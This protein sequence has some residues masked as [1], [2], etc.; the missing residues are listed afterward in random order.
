[1]TNPARWLWRIWQEIDDDV[2]EKDRQTL[3]WRPLVVL[4]VT[5]VSLTVQYYFGDLRFF[6]GFQAIPFEVRAGDWGELLSFAWWIGFRIVGFLFVGILAVL[7]MP[8]ERL[9]DYNLSWKGFINHW[10]PYVAF[11]AVAIPVIFLLSRLPAMQLIYPFYRQANRS[12][13]DLW[14]WE[15][16]YAAQ[17]ISLEFYFRGF[18][19]RALAP[20]LG[21]HSIWV[22][23]VP[24]VLIHFGKTFGETMGAIAFGI[25]LGTLALRTRSIWGGVLIHLGVAISMDLFTV[26]QLPPPGTGP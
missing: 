19:L 21:V 12:A 8:G 14:A 20:S 4:C 7:C 24:Y 13:F 11:L 1:M 22:M 3:D 9:R 26:G 10:K 25:M 17:F 18:M 6:Y 2:R 16:L 5:C 15:A 23:N